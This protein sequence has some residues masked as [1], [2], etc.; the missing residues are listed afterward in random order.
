[1]KKLIM[2][3]LLVATA[4]LFAEDKVAIKFELPAPHSSGTPKEVKSDNLEPDPGPGKG[5]PHGKKRHL[6]MLHGKG[7]EPEGYIRAGIHPLSCHEKGKILSQ[8]QDPGFRNTYWIIMHY[9]IWWTQMIS[10]SV[11]EQ[12]WKD[13]ILYGRKQLPG[14]LQRQ[15]KEHWSRPKWIRKKLI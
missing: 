5:A 15:H 9:P 13:D 12:E 3:A 2:T 14:W 1:M 11:S 6:F 8:E 7:I 10:G 4:G